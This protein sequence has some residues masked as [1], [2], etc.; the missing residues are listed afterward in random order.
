MGWG[1]GF[2]KERG[3]F[4]KSWLFGNAALNLRPSQTSS[5][6]SLSF[7][8]QS[9][10]PGPL[11][12]AGRPRISHPGPHHPGPHPGGTAGAVDEKGHPKEKR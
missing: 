6:L 2:F 9:L 7:L 5:S 8:P 10:P 12:W 11:A 1:E 3:H 4:P